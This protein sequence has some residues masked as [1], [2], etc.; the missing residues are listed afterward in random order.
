[1]EGKTM[2]LIRYPK[3][4]PWF[5]REREKYFHDLDREQWRE[6]L[7]SKGLHTKQEL[8]DKRI[9]RIVHSIIKIVVLIALIL[10]MSCTDQLCPSYRD[11]KEM[12][13]KPTKH[14]KTKHHGF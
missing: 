2:N 5:M 8:R 12:S 9:S 1:M 4:A 3:S 10:L 14:Y 13:N 7:H 6:L 11:N